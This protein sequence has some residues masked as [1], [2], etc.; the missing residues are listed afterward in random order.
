MRL[1]RRRR[2]S[3]QRL[4]AL[5]PDLADVAIGASLLVLRLGEGNEVPT[6][7]VFSVESAQGTRKEIAGQK[8][9]KP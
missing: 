1:P 6:A 4:A 3:L 9:R 5:S 7:L 8:I 2:R